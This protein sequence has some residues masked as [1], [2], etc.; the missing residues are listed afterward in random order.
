MELERGMTDYVR[1]HRHRVD[2]A[3]RA[4][5]LLS[6]DQQLQRA[7]E[8]LQSAQSRLLHAGQAAVDRKRGSFGPLAAQLDALSPLGIL[9]R[10]HTAAIAMISR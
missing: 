4:M 5:A 9:S 1:L 3:T 7:R 10:E 8:Q 6:P 2:Q